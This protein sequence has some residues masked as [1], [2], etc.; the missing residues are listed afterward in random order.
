MALTGMV[1]DVDGMPSGLYPESSQ[2][3]GSTTKPI[4]STPPSNNSRLTKAPRL[5]S[6]RQQH[7]ATGVSEKASELLPAAQ[8]QIQFISW[9]ESLVW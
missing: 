5:Q 4:Q 2:A 7:A 8:R 1:P 9:E 3:G 6:I